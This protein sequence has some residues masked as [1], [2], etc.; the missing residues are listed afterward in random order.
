[1]GA[2]RGRRR[3]AGL[4]AAAVS[5]ALT[6]AAAAGDFGPWSVDPRHPV[7]A[8]ANPGP[9]A[10][11]P[12]PT[13]SPF[14]LAFRVWSELLTRLD[15]PRCAHR[16]SCG[17]YARRALATHG[18]PLGMWMALGRLMRGAYSSALRVLPRITTPA[19][20]FFRDTLDDSRFWRP[21]YLPMSG[22]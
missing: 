7:V 1:M 6:T 3:A 15:G 2:H 21:G 12:L 4:I 8:G 9:A 17:V 20:V 13:A 18:L 10:G 16:P 11:R 22:R 14:I 5:V 19:G